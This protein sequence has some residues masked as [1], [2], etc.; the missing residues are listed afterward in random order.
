MYRI[1]ICG[2]NT[3]EGQYVPELTKQILLERNM[4]A[5]FTMFA[6]SCDLLTEL[7]EKNTGYDLLLLDML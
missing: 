7:Q 1:A 4:E 3:A 5:D 2:D 6:D